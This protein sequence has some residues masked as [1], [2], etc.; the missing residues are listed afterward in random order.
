MSEQQ[1]CYRVTV[2]S[3]RH[4]FATFP[5]AREVFRELV[6]NDVPWVELWDIGPGAGVI[7]C[8]FQMER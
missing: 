8:S 3:D 7:L 2:G 5:E 1:E 6:A 4:D